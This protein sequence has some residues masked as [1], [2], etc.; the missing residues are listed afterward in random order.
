MKQLKQLK[1]HISAI[2]C[3]AVLISV[4]SLS[5]CSAKKQSINWVLHGS[6]VYAENTYENRFEITMHGD[7]P[8]EL[9]SLETQTIELSIK[10]PDTFRYNN[11]SPQTYT[12][13]A[14][15]TRDDENGIIFMCSGTCYDPEKNRPTPIR[16][17][18]H[19]TKEF[20][21]FQWD[22]DSG[23]SYVAA[24]TDSNADLVAVFSDIQQA[25]DSASSSPADTEST[26][27]TINWTMNGA[28][29]IW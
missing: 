6:Y 21:V 1:Q 24:S 26:I 18:I 3:F 17:Y 20:V 12:I 22:T 14:L 29:V 27:N 4:I 10:W 16:F 28:L 8:T 11:P 9:E 7:L 19:P 2:C 25:L 5:A 23:Y 15:N 13:Q